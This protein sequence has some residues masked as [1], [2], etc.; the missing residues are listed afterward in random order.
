MKNA[1]ICLIALLITSNAYAIDE[2]FDYELPLIVVKPRTDIPS[3][4][5][6]C[7]VASF[8]YEGVRY[9]RTYLSNPSHPLFGLLA[10]ANVGRGT[11]TEYKFE[12]KDTAPA[13]VGTQFMY[14]NYST[15][16]ILSPNDL[17]VLR[18][19]MKVSSPTGEVIYQ[20]VCQDSSLTS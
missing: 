15:S 11:F 7:K 8:I 19:E 5:T 2:L 13:I 1:F 16:Y 9:Y 18:S 3:E 6:K 10:T 14:L 4:Y 17:R 20:Y 12:Y